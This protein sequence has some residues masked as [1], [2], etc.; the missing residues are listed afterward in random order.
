MPENTAPQQSML[1]DGSASE[2]SSTAALTDSGICCEDSFTTESNS[3]CSDNSSCDSQV[4]DGVIPSDTAADDD[5]SV[6]QLS[7]VESVG[8]DRAKDDS[9]DAFTESVQSETASSASLASLST[10]EGLGGREPHS[11]MFLTSKHGSEEQQDGVIASPKRET[12]SQTSESKQV[13]AEKV[14]DTL[15]CSEVLSGS[16]EST[17]QSSDEQQAG[18]RGS[19]QAECT[20]DKTVSGTEQGGEKRTPTLSHCDVLHGESDQPNSAKGQRSRDVFEVT[21]VSGLLGLG[22]TVRGDDFQDIVIQKIRMFSS[23]AT[24]GELRLAV[25]VSNYFACNVHSV[26]CYNYAYRVG[27]RILKINGSSVVGKSPAQVQRLLSGVKWGEE[28]K[29][30]AMPAQE[31]VAFHFSEMANAGVIVIKVCV[32]TMDC[33]TW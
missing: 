10:T 5:M 17:Q 31:L 13:D 15:S 2:K 7:L 11:E 30:L 14:R 32:E 9:V 8:S 19:N 28:V 4:G 21:L 20:E 3:E 18:V 29:L 26:I 23:A 12:L 33:V 24:Q 6:S 16:L 22:L 27:D 1:E 25:R